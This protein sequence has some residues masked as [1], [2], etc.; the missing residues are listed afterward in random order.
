MS[1]GLLLL[2]LFCLGAG[3]SVFAQDEHIPFQVGQINYFGYGG[4]DLAPIR[5][6]LPLHVG[7][8]ITFA[9]FDDAAIKSFIT[10]TI[11]HPPTDVG[12]VC[13]DDSKRLLIYIGLGGTSSRLLPTANSPRGSDHLATGALK[14]YDRQM[15]ALESAVRR[16]AAGEDDSKGYALNTDPALRQIEL[17]IHRYAMTREAEFERVLRNAADPRQRRAASEFL[18]YVP[19]SS[20]QIKALAEAV[21]D[22]DEEV[23]NNAVRA[24]SV[25]AAARNARPLAIDPQPF[26]A[27]LFSGKWTDRNKGSL[28]LA[29]LT[30]SR[31]PVLL[32]ALRKE[33]LQPL[34][35]GSSWSDS[36]HTGAFLMILGRIADIPE[37]KLQ[38][39]IA[40]GNSAAII[41]AASTAN[42]AEGEVPRPSRQRRARRRRQPQWR[43][44]GWEEAR[45]EKRISPLCC[46][47]R[48]RAA[49]VEMTTLLIGSD[50]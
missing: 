36:G 9:T 34:V 16:G 17:S 32:A 25:L 14:L 38:Q 22:S 4:I 3:S 27:L 5:A 30:E 18:G 8:T 33:A 35:E 19:R 2:V 48:T 20:M 49:S 1:K 45:V 41:A 50:N 12:T 37:D 40:G 46:S 47:Q 39:M 42:D 13:C 11:G 7:D 23:R 24:L 31:D 43:D 44:A 15:S 21:S 26:I 10:R 29:R 28:L 6:Q